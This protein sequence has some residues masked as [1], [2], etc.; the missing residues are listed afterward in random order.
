VIGAPPHARR[1]PFGATVPPATV[2]RPDAVTLYEA[3]KRLFDVL[4]A[5]ILLAITLPLLLLAAILVRYTSAGPVVFRQTR[6]GRHGRTFT[7][8]KLRTM[9]V[10]AERRKVELMHLNEVDG[11]VFKLRNDPRV[12]P[13]GRWLRKAS[14]DE[15]PQLVNVIVGQMSIVGPRPPLPEEV[16]QY[17]PLARQRLEVKPGLT[18]LWQVSGRSMIGFEQWM[19]LDLEYIRRRGFLFDL[20]I[21]LRT[22]PAVLT[23]RGAA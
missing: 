12:T 19:A 14:L 1:P 11:P 15:L 21:V 23:G 17:S 3:G 10:D 5:L 13:V 16:E 2:V 20:Q 6:C 18:C 7:C 9:Y 22:V 4:L 8:L